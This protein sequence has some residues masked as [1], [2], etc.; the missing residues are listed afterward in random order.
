[1]CA[2]VN[3]MSCTASSKIT[4]HEILFTFIHVL[5]II[6]YTLLQ[7][8]FIFNRSLSF[9]I[10]VI[11]WQIVPQLF[12]FLL[13]CSIFLVIM[14]LIQSKLPKKNN[15]RLKCAFQYILLLYYC[16]TCQEYCLRS[17]STMSLSMLYLFM[18]HST[19]L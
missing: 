11:I 18:R 15:F 6:C 14:V 19:F 5:K 8:N 1:M 2:W 13:K 3:K 7:F 4:K 12:F 10:F 16:V 17:Y 9:H